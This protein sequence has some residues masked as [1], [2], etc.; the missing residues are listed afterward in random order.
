[1]PTSTDDPRPPTSGRTVLISIGSVFAL[2]AAAIVVVVATRTTDPAAPAAGGAPTGTAVTESAGDDTSAA[3]L[4]GWGEPERVDEFTGP[5]GSDWDRYD[6][7]GHNGNGVRSPDAISV[8]DGLLT[9]TGD[10]DGTTGGVAWVP[11][12]RYGRWEARVRAPV[13]N[14]TYNALLLLWPDAEDW[15]VGGEVDFMELTDTSRQS[16][17]YFLH[18][19]QDNQQE[20]GEV[21]VDATQWHNWAVEWTPDH[22][23][24]Y[25]DGREWHRTTV[26]DRLPPRPMHLTIQLDWFP[27]GQDAAS[28]DASMQVDWV[29]Q[30]PMPRQ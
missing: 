30:Y 13:G 6:G 16:A 5:L 24:A 20:K 28:G 22:I 29:K 2:I 19:G 25:L 17:Q 12:Q 23:V 1:L 10:A 15:P 4:L 9:I 11:G 21:T 3:R 7:V 14:P 26:P 27:E 18:Y 8:H